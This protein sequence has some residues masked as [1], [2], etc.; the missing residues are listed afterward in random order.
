[1]NTKNALLVFAHPA[2]EDSFNGAVLSAT[3]EVLT[4]LNISLRIRLL[5][6]DN[7]NPVIDET[8]WRDS[9]KGIVSHDCAV[10]QEHINWADTLIFIT[11][12]WNFSIPAILKGYI[13]R[14]LMIPGFS[15]DM[16]SDGTNYKGGLLGGK[17]ALV[18]QTL[19]SKLSSGYK[20]ASIAS[21]IAPLVSSLY[22]T[23][24][25]N[26]KTFQIWN[27]YR[28]NDTKLALQQIVDFFL[29]INDD[30]QSR[31]EFIVSS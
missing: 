26:I 19:G 7:F 3:K 2:A 13:D 27:L 18:V 29:K 25:E 5:T 15:L 10:E 16:G 30:S 4:S 31:C 22:Y 28:G 24:I 9:F 23:G 12:A 21:Y 8:E 6:Q 11:P 20:Y 1:M 17:K 14:V